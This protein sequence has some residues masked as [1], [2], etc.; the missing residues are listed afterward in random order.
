MVARELVEQ[1]GAERQGRA[2]GAAEQLVQRALKQLCLQVEQGDFEGRHGGGARLVALRRKRSRRV[3]IAVDRCI[4]DAGQGVGV[5]HVHARQ[6]RRNALQ[7]GECLQVA[8]TLTQPDAAIG[9]FDLD[10]AA[11]RPGFVHAGDVEQRRVAKRDRGDAHSGDARG[12]GGHHAALRSEKRIVPVSD[13][14][15]ASQ[16][17]PVLNTPRAA[18]LKPSATWLTG[19][20]HR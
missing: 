12:G 14:R 7:V 19:S 16:R 15:G 6:L 13:S 20:R 11:Q 1:V 8:V 4:H 17:V 3:R 2:H 18:R 5:E 10:D 9:G